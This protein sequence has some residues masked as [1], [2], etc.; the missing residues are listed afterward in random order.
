MAGFSILAKLGLDSTKFASSLRGVKAKLQEFGSALGKVVK[1]GAQIAGA[2]IAGLAI[3]GIADFVQFEKGM[4]EV[5]T[6]LPE[7]TGHMKKQ[8]MGD[9]RELAH[10]MGVDL[11]DA[12]QGLYQ[13]ISAGIPEESAIKFLETA[14][15][16]SIGGVTDLSTA[17]A[18]LTTVMN[19]YGLAAD[20][21]GRVSDVLFTAV[22]GGMTTI[23][24][25]A[26]NVGK[27]TPIAAALGVS[28]EEVGAM[29]AT[30]TSSLGEGKTAQAGTKIAAM[31][32]ELGKAGTRASDVFQELA[33]ESFREFMQ[34]GG[35]VN[36]VLQ[37][38]QAEADRNK[39]SLVDMFGSIEAGQGALILAAENGAKLTK[40]LQAQA[41][42]AGAHTKAFLEMEKAMSRQWDKLGASVNEL[43]LKIGEAFM[44]YLA[45]ILP[46]FIATV[47]MLAP[48]F[49]ASSGSA[50]V[51]G[52]TMDGL[53]VIVG[54][55]LKTVLMVVNTL[56]M[57]GD[58][59]TFVGKQTA[60]YML[61]LKDM[62]KM[63]LQPLL[64]MIKAVGDAFAAMGEILSNPKKAAE[65]LKKL[66]K[67][68]LDGAKAM[69]GFGDAFAGAW[70][71]NLGLFK[72][73][74]DEF[75][76]NMAKRGQMYNKIWEMNLAVAGK[77]QV[78]NQA[79]VNPLVQGHNAARGIHVGL[80][81]AGRAATPLNQKLLLIKAQLEGAKKW[82]DK[83][84]VA[85]EQW[86]TA[87]EDGKTFHKD[88]QTIL[89]DLLKNDRLRIAERRTYTKMLQEQ[90][91]LEQDFNDVTRKGFNLLH[92]Q[93][94]Q[95]EDAA[96]ERGIAI[97][98]NRDLRDVY[99]E[100]VD[101]IAQA[102]KNM[103][104][105]VFMANMFRLQG[106]AVR[107]AWAEVAPAG[108]FLRDAET[109]VE[110]LENQIAMLGQ[111]PEKMQKVE[112]FG[113]LKDQ[114]G[115]AKEK[116]AELRK[117]LEANPLAGGKELGKIEPQAP[118]FKI[119]KDMDKKLGNID[120]KLGGF[121]INQ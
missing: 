75:I 25:L 73:N 99:D 110:N 29:F 80:K 117:E 51:F 57:W 89:I 37:A 93:K 45:Q 111:D 66:K 48:A 17:V 70:V 1:R 87:A 101:R 32:N 7:A 64:A 47:D 41:N 23:E 18:G 35:S 58:I 91:Q 86:N 82:A 38:M 52:A 16:L 77:A 27:V 42:G 62:G 88:T 26:H 4:R 28:L 13:S 81:G 112:R 71:K 76:G 8:M 30:M 12:V 109:D 116:A 100:I 53:V 55:L 40:E 6:L 68:S 14:T 92:L 97:K 98:D 108:K 61:V 56:G 50:Q 20:Q 115:K 106:I 67:A 107:D 31:L 84:K 114:L 10:S 24:E 83:C 44:P 74:N 69:S 60:T 15:K 19:G 49:T 43:G 94:V 113:V 65:G 104:D 22:K 90:K 3:K 105:N 103:E 36:Q 63:A 34:R 9:M 119:F 54:F 102:T 59:L 95:L 85:Q 118:D 2:A 96:E 46:M 39:M 33:G 5:F 121:F 120:E 72:K 79:A 78:A 21:A 11:N